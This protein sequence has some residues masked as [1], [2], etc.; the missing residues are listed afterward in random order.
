VDVRDA[1]LSAVA[2]GMRPP[3]KTP[4]AIPRVVEAQIPEMEKT[5]SHPQITAKVF[6]AP[7]PMLEVRPGLGHVEPATAEPQQGRGAPAFR[8]VGMLHQRFAILESEDGLVLFDPKAAKER[9]FYENLLRQQKDGGLDSQGLLVPVL[10]EMDPRDFSQILREKS[11]FSEAGI[12]LEAFG[13][14]TIQIHSLPACLHITNPR[15]FMGDLLDEMLH[16]PV[17]GGRFTAD[18]MARTLAKRAALLVEP[19]LAEVHSLLAE[20]FACELPYCA[21]DGRP[22]LTE[23]SMRELERRFGLLK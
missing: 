11:E 13:G 20:L 10:L 4:A 2:E 1:I 14:N 5:L 7:Q 8:I 9:V 18:R 15:P 12:E 23:L 19:K 21:V 16:T 6:P 3:T 17:S 22:T